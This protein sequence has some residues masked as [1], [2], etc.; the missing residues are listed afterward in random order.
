[1]YVHKI[2]WVAFGLLYSLADD[3]TS[4]GANPSPIQGLQG[5]QETTYN[6][7]ASTTQSSSIAPPST[8]LIDLESPQQP[9]HG[10]L[11]GPMVVMH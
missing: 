1:M 2:I 5:L 10:Q 6:T 8:N 4:S 7:A 11:N 9:I 3:Q